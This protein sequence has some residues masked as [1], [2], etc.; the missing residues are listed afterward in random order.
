MGAR[1]RC[2]KNYQIG[3]HGAGCEFGPTGRCRKTR[4]VRHVRREDININ[5][6]DTLWYEGEPFQ[7]TREWLDESVLNFVIV[8]SNKSY[9]FSLEDKVDED[10]G[11]VINSILKNNLCKLAAVR[12]DITAQFIG[13]S[14]PLQELIL[15]PAQLKIHEM[16][17]DGY[18]RNSIIDNYNQVMRRP[19]LIPPGNVALEDE[20]AIPIPGG[21]SLAYQPTNIPLE[22]YECLEPDKCSYNN[23]VGWSM[24]IN[25]DWSFKPNYDPDTGN[26]FIRIIIEGYSYYTTMPQWIFTRQGRKNKPKMFNEHNTKAPPGTRIFKLARAIVNGGVRQLDNGTISNECLFTFVNLLGATKCTNVNT[27]VYKLT[28]IKNHN[29]VDIEY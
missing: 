5:G 6:I 16:M 13:S 15:L 18:S 4:G 25:G 1:G 28:P 29:F 17:R 9:L 8:H 7:N 10:Y 26:I 2:S 21:N 23:T 24:N 11:D 27:P 12:T 22:L 14:Y 19:V 20:I 3:V